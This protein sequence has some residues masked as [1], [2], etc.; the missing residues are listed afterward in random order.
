MAAL[1]FLVGLGS[2]YLTLVAAVSVERRRE[3]PE[4]EWD[5]DSWES[6]RG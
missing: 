2:I 1:A 5:N 4:P 6:Q 3:V